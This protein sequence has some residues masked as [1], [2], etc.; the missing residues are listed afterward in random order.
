MMMSVH[1]TQSHVIHEGRPLQIWIQRKGNIE[2]TT[3][4]LEFDGDEYHDSTAEVNMAVKRCST[5][6]VSR[7]KGSDIFFLSKERFEK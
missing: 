5:M 4:G 3:S 6:D 7:R 2:R 1:Q